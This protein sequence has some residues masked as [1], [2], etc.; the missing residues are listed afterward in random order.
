MD[1]GSG[2]G[3]DVFIARSLVGDMGKIIGVDMTEAMIE[4]AKLNQ[5]KLGYRN[6][7]FR[8]GDLEDLPVADNEIDVVV[9]N[10]VLNLV[11]DKHKAFKEMSARLNDLSR[12]TI[13][14]GFK[15]TKFVHRAVSAEKSAEK[16]L[17]LRSDHK[18]CA[19]AQLG[20]PHTRPAF[21]DTYRQSFPAHPTGH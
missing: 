18:R 20:H 15:K 13:W 11:P 5:E 9:S 21:R 17:V 16:K 6:I 4:K 12:F 14:P 10:C 2:A 1:L 3:N 19:D 8:L 7:D